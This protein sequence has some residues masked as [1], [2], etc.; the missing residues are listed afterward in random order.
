LRHFSKLGPMLGSDCRSVSFLCF[1]MNSCQPY[2]TMTFE[3]EILLPSPGIHFFFFQGQKMPGSGS[4]AVSYLSSTIS[5][6]CTSS[7]LIM[8]SRY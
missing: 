2:T 7:T 3:N 8:R 6:N 5:D 1:F 4:S